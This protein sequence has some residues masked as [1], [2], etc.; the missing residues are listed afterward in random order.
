MINQFYNL[1][2][3]CLIT[4]RKIKIVFTAGLDHALF[5]ITN[6]TNTSS[7][8]KKTTQIYISYGSCL[9]LT[10]LF[11]FL[12]FLF[13]NASHNSYFSSTFVNFF[14]SFNQKVIRTTVVMAREVG[15]YK[16]RNA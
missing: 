16:G 7:K 10:S 4:S 2:K 12:L 9:L 14:R 6:Y 1:L 13:G 15:I 8:K 3:R 11:S 5:S